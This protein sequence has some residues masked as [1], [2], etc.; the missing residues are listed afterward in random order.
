MR[1]LML[2]LL[3][4]F[5]AQDTVTFEWTQ[6][7]LTLSYPANWETP[8][9]T[10]IDGNPSLQLAEVLA[11]TPIDVRPPGI[12]TIILSVVPAEGQDPLDLLGSRLNS[13][14][15]DQLDPPLE[16]QFM[17]DIAPGLTGT[18]ADGQL[19]G[20]AQAA[21][22][23][24]DQTLV[25]VGRSSTD[26]RAEFGD[27]FDTVA[28]SIQISGGE[29]PASGNQ[30]APAYGILWYTQRDVNDAENAFLNLIGLD[31][32][33]GQQLYTYE[34]DLGVVQIDAHSGRVQAITP[35]PNI[36][37]PSDLAVG[38]DGS[39]YVADLSCACIFTLTADDV[40][41]DLPFG[42]GVEMDAGTG[43]MT[44][45]GIEFTRASGDRP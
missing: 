32:G 42:E 25:M 21:P 36:S 23:S 18:N 14:G 41:L 30:N 2:L 12:P 29:G 33:P 39:V 27:L 11:D 7:G 8:A 26:Q 34:A 5:S 31:L 19:F 28:G 1:F 44:G 9:A 43:L 13:I 10:E 4:S 38:S 15:I 6:A 16:V 22:L 3:L 20:I 45:F 37:F 24:A 35:N 17:G 40:W